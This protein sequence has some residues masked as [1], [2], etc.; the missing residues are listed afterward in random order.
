M[1]KEVFVEVED[2][3]G[4]ARSLRKYSKVEAVHRVEKNVESEV[5]LPHDLVFAEHPERGLHQRMLFRHHLPRIGADRLVC[6]LADEEKAEGECL[7]KRRREECIELAAI[8]ACLRVGVEDVSEVIS[9][10]LERP[11]LYFL[12]AELVEPFDHAGSNQPRCVREEFGE[13]RSVRRRR[14]LRLR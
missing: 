14:R 10:N 1:A 3:I 8:T 9:D 4:S 2:R 6:A 7:G 12:V 5:D 11:P 13:L